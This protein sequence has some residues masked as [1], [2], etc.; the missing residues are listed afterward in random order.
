MAK[1]K[2]NAIETLMYPGGEMICW[3]PAY[4][5]KDLPPSDPNYGSIML[6]L[7]LCEVSA[8]DDEYSVVDNMTGR[9][10]SPA[11]MCCVNQAGYH[12]E[13]WHSGKAPGRKLTRYTADYD[14][15][16]PT[17]KTF[18]IRELGDLTPFLDPSI[19][20]GRRDPVGTLRIVDP[21]TL[22]VEWADGTSSTFR[23]FS[24]RATLSDRV[25]EQLRA[26]HFGGGHP[27]VDGWLADE[28]QPISQKHFDAL[29][30]VVI[31]D[32]RS[33]DKPGFASLLHAVF[34]L[35]PTKQSPEIME[36]IRSLLDVLDELT[37]AF[38][39]EDGDRVAARILP[40]LLAEDL[41][42]ASP[43]GISEKRTRYQWLQRVLV[44]HR[45]F[46]DR[47]HGIGLITR[48]L[49]V[50]PPKTFRYEIEGAFHVAGLDVSLPFASKLVKAGKY[51]RYVV[52]KGL[53][54]V[55]DK[56]EEF[57][58]DWG[59][60]LKKYRDKIEKKI[61]DKV[62]GALADLLEAHAGAK[63]LHGILLVRA[64][65]GSW[66]A[67]Y[68]VAG[69]IFAGGLGGTQMGIETM[70]AKGYAES[71]IDWKPSSFP[72]SF[73]ILPG[74]A[75]TDAHGTRAAKQMIWLLDGGGTTGKMQLTFDEVETDASDSDLGIGWG[76]VFDLDEDDV[77][78]T[79]FGTLP[80]FEY[81]TKYEQ[82]DAIQ[83][84]LGS[85]TVRWSGRQMLRVFAANEL[86]LIRDPTSRI[87][88][89]G[90]A[91][92]IGQPWYNR[93]LSSARALNIQTA[94]RDCLGSDLVAKVETRGHG[95][96]VIASISEALF[97][98]EVASEQWRRGFVIMNGQVA[99]TLGTNDP[100]VRKRKG[101]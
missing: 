20:V 13:I 4:A 82:S 81:T 7:L 54:K 39:P 50:A 60:T 84:Q 65:D 48:W 71:D 80:M 17:A 93:Q 79:T 51:G 68:A 26:Q 14:P 78:H 88:V 86:A 62:G 72:G 11:N 69:T 85:A 52:K 2:K 97:P 49:G 30:S 9:Y 27:I 38:A 92:R 32:R 41:N 21:V 95:E 90:F 73:T 25:L 37:S 56:V 16:A 87:D 53:K 40:L 35:E 63:A 3:A 83:F 36:A 6:G 10:E 101:K 24:R 58:W 99:A 31:H 74:I 66:E 77:H 28:H 76:T 46:A 29:V 34:R 94:L 15:A 18:A 19:D 70:T 57:R 23:R 100:T 5:K 61:V 47:V 59:Q 55:L 89:E 64:P 42:L 75:A 67:E 91:D 96:D 22:E 33:G 45:D 8:P 98:D 12:M 44:Y 43:S 1:A